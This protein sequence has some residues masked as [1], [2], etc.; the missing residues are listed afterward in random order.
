MFQSEQD[1]KKDQANRDVAIKSFDENIK[2]I[3]EIKAPPQIER[4]FT[5]SYLI[6][7][8]NYISKSRKL[9]PLQHSAIYRE[10]TLHDIQTYFDLFGCDIDKGLFIDCMYALDNEFLKEANK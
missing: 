1:F 4:S 7:A 8:F 2:K 3:R 10:I 5:A 6:R 9:I